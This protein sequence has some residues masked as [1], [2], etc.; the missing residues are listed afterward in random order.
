MIT[1]S[2]I[3]ARFRGSR[4]NRNVIRWLKRVAAS[5]TTIATT[6]IASA[7]TAATTSADSDTVVPR[8]SGSSSSHQGPGAGDRS[9]ASSRKPSATNESA[10]TAT[11]DLTSGD[12][13]AGLRCKVRRS[14]STASSCR[15][16]FEPFIF[17]CE[18]RFI[19]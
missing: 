15:E 6:V 2:P 5:S 8:R 4:T 11:T 14:V 19:Q 9:A 16:G 10:A 3:T 1:Y 18:P 12:A 17:G 13:M 7:S